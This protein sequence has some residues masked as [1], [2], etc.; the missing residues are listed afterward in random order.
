MKSRIYVETSV[1][2]F[3]H[4]VRTE[5][6]MI[7]R[8][9]WTRQFWATADDEYSLVTSVAVIEELERGNFPNKHEALESINSIPLL[10]TPDEIFEIVETYI[11]HKMMPSDPHGDAMHLAFASYFKCDFLLTWNCKHLANAKKFGH[12]R[13]INGM[14]GLYVPMLVTPM[15]LLGVSP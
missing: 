5:P 12:I 13:K 10:P 2:S 1:V 11:R 3:Y 15:E 9:D 14:L 6:D 8:R 4:E 7:A